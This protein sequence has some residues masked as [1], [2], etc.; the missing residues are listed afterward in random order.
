MITDYLIHTVT[1]KPFAS[2][3][4][5]NTKTFAASVTLDC[6]EHHREIRMFDP[7]TG[8]EV[9]SGNQITLAPDV[10]VDMKDEFTL[11]GVT[12]RVAEIRRRDSFVAVKQM[13]VLI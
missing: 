5:K 8:Q 10:S 12:Y 9:M 6:R 3:D 11:N 4:Y 7:D 1:H 2:Y 13:V